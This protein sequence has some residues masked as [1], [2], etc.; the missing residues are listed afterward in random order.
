[1][2]LFPGCILFCIDDVDVAD[3]TTTDDV[4]EV[5]ADVLEGCKMT[6]VGPDVAVD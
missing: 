4:T 1:M 6:K 3:V 2:P 5:L